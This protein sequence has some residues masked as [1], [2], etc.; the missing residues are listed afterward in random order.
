MD[1]F[2]FI[3]DVA[4][5]W[6]KS[7]YLLAEPGDY[8]VVARKA[9]DTGKWFAGGVTDENSRTLN[10]PMNF[11]EPGKKYV[12]KIYADAENADYE[13]N[14]QAYRIYEKVVTSKTV[15]PIFL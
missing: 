7:K 6:Q 2:K 3:K 5:D 4:V 13:T 9:K 10:V 1:A 15:L 12:A 11:L 14:P 8:I